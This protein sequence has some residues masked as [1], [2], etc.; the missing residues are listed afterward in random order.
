MKLLLNYLKSNISL[1]HSDDFI[2]RSAQVQ[3]RGSGRVRQAVGH[4]GGT[5]RG[6]RDPLRGPRAHEDP[7]VH[8]GRG[9][10]GGQPSEDRE[11]R[12]TL[13]PSAHQVPAQDLRGGEDQAKERVWNL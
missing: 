10:A 13:P 6:L 12:N 3:E 5:E 8:R 9:G 4:Q 7:V 11:V 1:N 2:L